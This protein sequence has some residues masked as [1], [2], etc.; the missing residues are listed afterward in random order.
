MNRFIIVTF[1]MF[2]CNWVSGQADYF[3][4][5]MG[6]Y[7]K[8][9]EPKSKHKP[10]V[11]YDTTYDA[12]GRLKYASFEQFNTLGK[13]TYRNSKN[14]KRQTF[15]TYFRDTIYKS[16]T[17]LWK[18]DTAGMWW[19]DFNANG[20]IIQYQYAYKSVHKV[21]WSQS[22]LYDNQM[23]PVKYENKNHKGEVTGYTA[24]LYSDSGKVAERRYYNKKGKLKSVYSY[25]CD[26]KGEQL[27]NV[28]SV[29]YC[30]S[31]GVHADGR[32]YETIETIRDGKASRQIYT[33]SS[34]SLL[35]SY[36]YTSVKGKPKG[37]TIY[38]YNDQQLC[39][40][41]EIY[42]AKGKKKYINEFSYNSRGYR[43][44]QRSYKANGKLSSIQKSSYIWHN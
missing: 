33:Y 34:D 37:K 32:F 30:T 8:G 3:S 28:S 36:E 42:D 44:E 20:K 4:P 41:Y 40:K 5:A 29:N 14:G 1:L 43:S 18:G 27:K 12:K 17:T 2:F 23:R 31:K 15:Y 9:F 38:F 13:L 26:A 24:I 35:L 21:K 22:T 6:R 25:A 19:Y 7:H 10:A 39:S 11:T 16:A